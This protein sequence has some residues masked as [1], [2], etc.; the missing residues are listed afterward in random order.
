MANGDCPVGA[1]NKT[2]I[3][4]LEKAEVILHNRVDRVG[5]KQDWIFYLII[6]NLTGMVVN[7]VSKFM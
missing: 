3:A 2:A 4:A 5:A 7:L 6:A 1:A